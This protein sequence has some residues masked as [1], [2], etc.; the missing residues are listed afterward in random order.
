MSTLRG[1]PFV[2]VTRGAYTESV[3]HV[4]ACIADERGHVVHALGDIDEPVFLRSAA[5][6]LIAADVVASGAAARFGFD[7]RELAVMAASHNG[8]AF[9]VATVASILAKIGLDPSALQCGAHAPSYQPAAVALAASGA[10]PTALHNNC[11]G[12]HAGIL[13]ACVHLGLDPSTYLALEHPVQQRILA[14]CA[15]VL[16]EPVAR[17]PVAVD[18][19]GIPAF[20]T[21]LR[22]AA[23]GFARMATLASLDDADAAALET[24]RDA[25]VAE[26]AY[27]GGSERFDSALL[28]ATG[29]RIVAKSGAEGVHADA[30]RREGLGLVLKVVD[31]ARRAAAPAAM[32]LLAGAGAME[33]PEAVVLERFAHAEVRNVAGRIVG[34]VTSFA[35]DT[36]SGAATS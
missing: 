5:K 32:A 12:K 34:F 1:E 14:F 9:H 13:A 11:S 8:E 19:C 21:P 31:G 6:P 30:L 18:G 3:H 10:L 22:R 29:G 2:Y 28:A 7:A 33:P 24:V 25:M 27:V 26:P 23:R 20:A 35:A 17:M 15:R 36:I 16:G 4:A